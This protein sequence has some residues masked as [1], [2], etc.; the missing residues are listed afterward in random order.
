MLA[1][2]YGLHV[3]G[4]ECAAHNCAAAHH[5]AWMVR[6]KLRD[7]TF[8]V[9]NPKGSDRGQANVAAHAAAAAAGGG[10]K[11]AAKAAATAAATAAVAASLDA[12]ADAA[13][14]GV[15]S[16]LVEHGGGS[17]SNLVVRLQPTATLEWL[18]ET[19]Q[20]AID[21]IGRAA[22]V[23]GGEGGGE[24]GGKGGGKG[25]GE[26]DASHHRFLLV[27][28]HTCGDLSPTL[29]R[30]AATSVQRERARERPQLT[31][32]T[33]QRDSGPRCVGVVSVGCCYHRI[34]EPLAGEMRPDW[35]VV[36]TAEA[37]P[38]AADPPSLTKPSLIEPAAAPAAT[39]PP[40]PS[41]AAPETVKH[42]EERSFREEHPQLSNFPMSRFCQRLQISLGE[43][44]LHLSL[45]AV[46][47]WPARFTPVEE[48]TR[49]C[50]H[51]LFRCVV[52]CRLQQ[53]RAPTA[54]TDGMKLPR[55][56]NVGSIPPCE[57]FAE[58]ARLAC[59]RVGL[60]WDDEER[61]RMATLWEA[62]KHLERP[63][64]CFCMLRGVL[65]RPIERII[66]LD[67]LLFMREAGLKDASMVEIF[68]PRTSPR[69]TAI[70]AGW[71]GSCG[72]CE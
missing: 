50:R 42:A 25:G 60:T 30:L 10:T 35:A 67:R 38:K 64:R 7:K 49:R 22:A 12:A 46:W 58:Y 56:G 65:Q 9:G 59:E 6:E 70:I 17:F 8:R 43:I 40:A 44:A 62:H 2:H 45:Q 13:S 19:L 20:G 31:R 5:R 34:S 61:G 33:E 21:Q 69:S 51:H 57:T 41:S 32:A 29:L 18:E 28:L 14:R 36:E 48:T 55:D 24:G 27:G 37:A 23:K 52:E 4:L 47:R 63:M 72:P 71:A 16:P 39:I 53:L 66:L 15:P 1:F 68:D 26:G 54:R 11:A 3:V